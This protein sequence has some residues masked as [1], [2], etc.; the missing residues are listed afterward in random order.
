MV[1]GW[2]EVQVEALFEW[3]REVFVLLF[4]AEEMK[5]FSLIF[6][7]GRGLHEGW[8]TIAEKFCFSRICLLS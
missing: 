7:E 6:H 4:V 5:R 1:G 3:S 8:S 2:E